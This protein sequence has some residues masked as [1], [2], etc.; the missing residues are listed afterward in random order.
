MY[1]EGAKKQV[2]NY[3]ENALFKIF[4]FELGQNL[5]NSYFNELSLMY[6]KQKSVNYSLG[7]VC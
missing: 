6:A 1:F 7:G 3:A 4:F 2:Y 5:Q